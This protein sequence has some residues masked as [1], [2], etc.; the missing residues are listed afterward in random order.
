MSGIDNPRDLLVSLQRLE[1]ER[2]ADL[3]RRQ[4]ILQAAVA[5]LSAASQFLPNNGLS[6][7]ATVASLLMVGLAFWLIH[8]SRQRRALGEKARRATLLV[9]GLGLKL[10]ATELRRFAAL[11]REP[12]D[13]LAK[14]N[15]PA[16]YDASDPPSVQRAAAMLEESAFWSVHLFRASAERMQ[17]WSLASGISVLVCLLLALSLLPAG[18][19]SSAVRLFSTLT[20][21][22]VFFETLGRVIQYH[23][24]ANE[25]EDVL[26]HLLR[27]RQS[28]YPKDDFLLALVNY[29]SAV[30]GAPMMAPGVYKA[31]RDRLN[32]IWREKYGFQPTP[33]AGSG[34][35]KQGP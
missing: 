4:L 18:A 22:W 12:P 35:A 15:D 20:S 10:S 7:L 17:I 3:D 30:E 31:N 5:V 13:E 2:S 23:S 26:Q 33:A 9:D 25:A 28:G 19:N 1:F 14:W 6:A 34:G 24:A 16:Y 29:N 27:I 21:S 32:K 8:R 11:S